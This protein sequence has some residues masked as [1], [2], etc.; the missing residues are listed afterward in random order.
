MYNYDQFSANDY[1]LVNFRG[2]MP[3]S[4]AP[5]VTVAGLDGTPSR[6]LDFE[7]DFLVLEMGSLTCPL[8]QGRRK[9]MSSLHT[10]YPNVD[11][12]V[13]YVREAHPGAAISSHQSNEDKKGC[14]TLLHSDGER[15][16][17][18]VDDLEG[19]AHRAFGGYPNSVFIINRNGCVVYA[20]DWNNPEATGRALSLLLEG[21]PA[22]LKAWF[23]PVAPS[24]SLRILRAGG[25]GS[26]ADFLRG[27]PRLI[28]NNLVLRNIR[29]LR[30][31]SVSTPPDAVC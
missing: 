15:R 6:L 8:F 19:T 9:T 2:P 22:N 1:D 3:G 21:K 18:L 24:V 28:W 14:A 29:L 20:S 17:I 16:N 23:K 25:K 4:P 31:K 11:F 5:D 26:L 12:A 30:G 10:D 13:L 7:G 27:L